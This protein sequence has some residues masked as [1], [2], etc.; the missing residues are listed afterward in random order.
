MTGEGRVPEELRGYEYLTSLE[1]YLAAGVRLGTRMSNKYLER[2]GFIYSVRPDGLRVFDLKHIDD[3]IRVAARMISRYD[4]G[5][6][7]AHTTRPYGYRPIE[8]FCKYVGCIAVPGRFVPGTFTNPYLDHYIEADLLI[9]ADP[10]VDGQAVREAAITGMPVIALVDTD[11]PH[12]YVD[13]IIPC[14]NKGRKSLALVFWLLALQTLRE[15]G[16]IGP[17]EELPV[18][19]EEF[20]ARTVL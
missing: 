10:R 7:V 5:K 9:V 6:V 1:K 19:Y 8:M 12:E 3:R 2:R 17:Q 18:P 14:N 16:T 15:R 11:T 4:P 13:L 20:E